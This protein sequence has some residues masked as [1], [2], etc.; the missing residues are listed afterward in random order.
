MTTLLGKKIHQLRKEKK[1]TLEELAGKIG[2]GKSYV[3]EIENRDQP[4]P[5][6]DRLASIA[7]ALEVTVEFLLDDT[8][9]TPG[10]EVLDQAFY[11]LYG[12]MNS[13][14]KKKLK[15]IAEAL[16]DEK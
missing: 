7:R 13:E 5:S 4:N 1:L 12:S 16:N 9:A 2:A 11:R 14:T 3:W 6:A 15:R 8:T 10:E